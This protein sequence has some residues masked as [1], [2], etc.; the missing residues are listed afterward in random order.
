MGA[1]PILLGGGASNQSIHQT[2]SAARHPVGTMGQL[3]DGRTYFYAENG[4][5]ALAPGKLVMAEVIPSTRANLAVVAAVAAGGTSVTVTLGALLAT[6]NDYAEGYL[7][8]NDVD[9]EGITYKIRSHPAADSGA[10]VVIELYDPIITAL[11]TSSQVTLQKN[12]YK[13]VVIAAAGK[14]HQPV[15]VAPIPVP[16]N[17]YA[18]LLTNGPQAAWADATSIA[19]GDALQSGT[20]AGQVELATEG[21]GTM[22]GQIGI[23]LYTTVDTEYYPVWFTI[24]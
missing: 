5:T 13:K 1:H 4:G 21:A 9:G 3:P 18:W 10:N 11:T 19:I 12:P 16:A 2:S 15:G 23:N 20:T 24:R 8:V 17:E 22:G 14:V 7:H 6:A